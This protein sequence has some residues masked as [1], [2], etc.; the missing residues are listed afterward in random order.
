MPYV[1]EES[2]K[3]SVTCMNDGVSIVLHRYVDTKKGYNLLNI[4]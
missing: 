4:V 1:Y 3:V 2:E